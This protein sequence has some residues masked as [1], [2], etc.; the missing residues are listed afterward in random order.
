MSSA[1]AASAASSSTGAAASAS[2]PSTPVPFLSHVAWRRKLVVV[3]VGLPAR[4]KSYVASKIVGWQRWRG[5]SAELFNVGKFR[6]QELHSQQDAAFFA[7][8]NAQAQSTR[9]ALAFSVLDHTLKWLQQGGDLAVLDATNTTRKR[10]SEVLARIRAVSSVLPVCFIESICTD[11]LVL[12]RNYL[13]KVTHS[14]DYKAMS[15][16]DALEDLQKRVANYERVYEPLDEGPIREQVSYIKLINLASKCVC[17]QIHGTLMHSIASFLMSIHVQPRP[18]YLTRAGRCVGASDEPQLA[19]AVPLIA[20]LPASSS[21][22]DMAAAK[23]DGSTP[24]TNQPAATREPVVITYSQSEAASLDER[25]ETYARL[26]NQFVAEQVLEYWHTH[27]V[28]HREENSTATSASASAAANPNRSP[29]LIP[30]ASIPSSPE[31]AAAP[32]ISPEPGRDGPGE[33][34]DGEG[35]TA[36]AEVSLGESAASVRGGHDLP[37]R[38][39]AII[40]SGSMKLQ[41][42]RDKTSDTLPLVLYTSTLPRAL[43]TVRLISERALYVQQQSSLNALDHGTLSGLTLEQVKEKY[44]QHHRDWLAQRYKFRFPG[45]ESQQDKARALEQLV[46]ELER[47]LFPVLLVSHASTLQILLGYFSSLPCEE[48]S[49]LRISQHILIE[50]IPTNYGR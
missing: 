31:L 34:E 27:L 20:P 38:S 1:P 37:E 10:R 22:A 11:P 42:K 12:Q 48:Y 32:L 17:N 23:A 46:M 28:S 43:Q 7:P 50:L 30:P 21:C 44:P 15:V 5:A 25:G 3:L 36:I 40:G 29:P 8:D 4:G 6:R 49:S 24:S 9:D 16:S 47:Q 14:P 41:L 19:G 35:A 26:M 2:C 39:T 33:G 13:A 18:I 45:G